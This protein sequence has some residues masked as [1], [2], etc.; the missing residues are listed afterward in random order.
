MIIKTRQSVSYC[1]KGILMRQIA[2]EGIIFAV[3]N[4]IVNTLLN[5]HAPQD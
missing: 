2:I 3:L 4:T 5:K 1:V